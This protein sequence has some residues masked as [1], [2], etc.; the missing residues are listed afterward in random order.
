MAGQRRNCLGGQHHLSSGTCTIN[1]RI[2]VQKC[3][4]PSTAKAQTRTRDCSAL[5]SSNEETVRPLP[6]HQIRKSPPIA[7]LNLLRIARVVLV[8]SRLLLVQYILAGASAPSQRGRVRST[9]CELLAPV[10]KTMREP[11][12]N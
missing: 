12:V 5:V 4:N 11:R 8:V 9:S 6:T 2:I 1:H 3:H 7:H 10:G